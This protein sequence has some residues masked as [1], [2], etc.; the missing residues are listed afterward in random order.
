[1]TTIAVI[2]NPKNALSSVALTDSAPPGFP[3]KASTSPHGDQLPS[4]RRNVD[5]LARHHAT[6]SVAMRLL[7]AAALVGFV[8]S[9]RATASA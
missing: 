4:V 7:S 2:G 6:L 8:A 1:M 3:A 9:A 5:S